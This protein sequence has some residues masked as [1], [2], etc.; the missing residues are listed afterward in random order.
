MV[1]MGRRSGSEGNKQKRTPGQPLVVGQAI[2]MIH[3]RGRR[4]GQNLLGSGT[5]GNGWVT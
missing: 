3:R 5:S 2:P 1:R 4:K